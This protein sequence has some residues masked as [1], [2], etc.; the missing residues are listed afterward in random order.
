MADLEWYTIAIL[1]VTIIISGAI[2]A[3]SQ[4]AI[5]GY[6]NKKPSIG[7]RIDFWSRF[8]NSF[9]ASYLPNCLLITDG[10]KEYKYNSLHHAQVQISNE[11]KQDFDILKFGITLSD[12]NFA[13][14][15]EVQSSDRHHHIE[16]LTP[17]TFAE[18]KSQVDFIVQPLNRGDSYFLRLLILTSEDKEHPGEIDI[19][20][21]QAVCFVDLPTVAELIEEAAN[22][23][24]IRLGPFRISLGRLARRVLTS[25]TVVIGTKKR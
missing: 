6:R 19:S 5:S 13:V 10:V 9:G 22:R 18:P 14:Y 25:S 3:F 24:S 8:E 20:S 15:A 16:Q 12:D 21:P 17:V 7:T 4:A 2:G 1:V 11:S 23:A